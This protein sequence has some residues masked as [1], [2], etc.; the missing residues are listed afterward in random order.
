MPS[1][2]NIWNQLLRDDRRMRKGDLKGL[3]RK[4]WFAIEAAECGLRDAMA[5]GDGDEVRRWLHIISQLSGAYSK[6][7]VDGD[8]EQRVKSIEQR[9]AGD[10]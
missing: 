6:A 3:L 2:E 10:G 7:A 9:V 8:L 5:A 4:L 1:G